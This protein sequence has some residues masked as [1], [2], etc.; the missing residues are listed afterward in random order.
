MPKRMAVTKAARPAAE[1]ASFEAERK[2]W[3][4]SKKFKSTAIAGCTAL[5]ASTVTVAVYTTTIFG[6]QTMPIFK[7]T[8][9]LYRDRKEMHIFLARALGK[10]VM[11]HFDIAMKVTETREERAVGE[12]MTI[13]QKLMDALSKWDD[14]SISRSIIISKSKDQNVSTGFLLLPGLIARFTATVIDETHVQYVIRD[15]ASEVLMMKGV[16]TV[17]PQSE[18]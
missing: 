8:N 13:E 7:M 11:E 15:M 6:S 14:E 5:L 4:F 1:P 9:P 18:L 10:K 2:Y 12:P 16:F 17:A 3:T